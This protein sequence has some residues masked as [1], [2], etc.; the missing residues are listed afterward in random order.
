MTKVQFRERTVWTQKSD[1][2]T[3][4]TWAT[5]VCS[6]R[7]DIPDRINDHETWK[8]TVTEFMWPIKT[9]VNSNGGQTMGTIL[10]GRNLQKPSIRC[11]RLK[12]Q[13]CSQPPVTNNRSLMRTFETSKSELCKEVCSDCSK[14]NVWSGRSFRAMDLKLGSV[15]YSQ[16]VRDFFFHIST[17]CVLWVECSGEK[18]L[19]GFNE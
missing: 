17:K 1:L 16:W 12:G 13:V 19:H 2:I 7:L 6:P 8:W 9:R 15:K 5:F 14:C 4:Q 3:N 11:V 18:T 10:S